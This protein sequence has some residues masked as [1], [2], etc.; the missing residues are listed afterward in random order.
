M[1]SNYGKREWQ[2]I[3]VIGLMLIAASL[4]ASLW[5]A[6]GTITLLT[7]AL[8]AFFRDPNRRSPSQR[9][10]VVCP[11]DGR[12]S[13]IHHL[14]H[15]EPLGEPVWCVRIF[16]SLF[17]VHVNRC[18]CHAVVESIRHKSGEHRNAMNPRS[19]ED[20][21]SNLLILAHPTQRYRIAAVRQVAGMLARSIV[22]GV[23]EQQIIQ[24]G[25]R[26]GMIKLGSTIELYLP[27]SLE[28]RLQVQEG[29][30]VYGGVTV[31]ALLISP[32]PETRAEPL[33]DTRPEG[34]RAL[35]T[36]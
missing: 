28:P 4:I 10:V 17:D 3:L 12:V 20:N 8:L 5:W 36:P 9:G 6:A 34:P 24:R 35:K 7:L 16:L 13:S 30:Y 18:P 29:E 11:G 33:T 15:F 22:C 25:Q 31:A 26:F 21:E 27:D 14:E 32:V 2:T 1:L 19:A 23:K